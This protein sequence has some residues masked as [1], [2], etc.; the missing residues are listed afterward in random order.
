MGHA[1]MTYFLQQS[2]ISESYAMT[3]SM[4]QAIGE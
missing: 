4:D 2:A 3:P 1:P